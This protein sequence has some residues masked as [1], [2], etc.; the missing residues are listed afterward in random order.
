M[1]EISV[2]INQIFFHAACVTVSNTVMS[3]YYSHYH[4]MYTVRLGNVDNNG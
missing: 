1:E 3:Q 4:D 2:V